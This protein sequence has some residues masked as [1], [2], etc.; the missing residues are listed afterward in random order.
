MAIDMDRSLPVLQGPMQA[1]PEAVGV[2]N[3]VGDLPPIVPT[4]QDRNCRSLNRKKEQ[5]LSYLAD[6][7]HLD[8]SLVKEILEACKIE[9]ETN[10]LWP[11]TA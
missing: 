2:K 5:I 7:Q 8:P 10:E 1:S 11:L 6:Y 3:K 9:L 4:R